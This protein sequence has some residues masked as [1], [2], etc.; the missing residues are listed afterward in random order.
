MDTAVLSADDVDRMNAIHQGC[1]H[2]LDSMD[3]LLSLLRKA[4]AAP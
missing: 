2:L 3:N 4:K 1:F